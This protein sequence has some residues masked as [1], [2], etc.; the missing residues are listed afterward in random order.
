MPTTDA[1]Q[2][3]NLPNY[4]FQGIIDQALTKTLAIIADKNATWMGDGPTVVTNYEHDTRGYRGWMIKQWVKPVIT[5]QGA[6]EK[7]TGVSA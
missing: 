1:Q 3:V 7:L 6:I 5:Q 4:G 2:M